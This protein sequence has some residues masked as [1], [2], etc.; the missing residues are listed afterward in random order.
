MPWG[1]SRMLCPGAAAASS[2]Q[3]SSG[4]V[5]GDGCIT[6]CMGKVR[7]AYWGVWVK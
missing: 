4:S 2:R 7:D 1:S 3:P 5:V 6:G